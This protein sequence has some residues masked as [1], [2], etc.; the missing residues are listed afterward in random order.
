MDKFN[1]KE[2][3]PKNP[4]ESALI[5]YAFLKCGLPLGSDEFENEFFSLF[6]V[7]DLIESMKYYIEK[8]S[9]TAKITAQNYITN[10]GEFFDMLRTYGIVNDI[11]TDISL[12]NQLYTKAKEATLLL[13]DSESKDI[14][15]DELYEKLK[16]G[17]DEYFRRLVINDIYE[18]LDR[19]KSGKL[20]YVSLYNRF[21]SG[22]AIKIITQYALSNLTTI[23]LNIEDVD[24]DN[25]TLT[26]NGFILEL[27]D[28]L[29][30]LLKDYLRI[31][32]Y[33]LRTSSMTEGKLFVKHNG[34]PYIKYRNDRRNSPNYVA[35][36]YILKDIVNTRSAEIFASRRI[37]ELLNKGLDI[38]TVA[39]LSGI[40]KEKCEE[41]QEKN[42]NK[43]EANKKLSA[44]LSGDKEI[45]KKIIVN[46]K[47]FLKCPF[48]GKDTKAI[49]DDWVLVQLKE[50]GIK[51][52][53]CG[54]CKGAN[55]KA[56]L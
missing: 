31:R 42:Q 19:I 26:V 43:E 3:I 35:F 27:T 8:D 40:S 10:I 15:D 47:G 12:K 53:A 33:V 9:I 41:L 22:I 4:K 11:F 5:E 37:L 44:I 45:D 6:T 24:I 13:K 46:K 51:Y 23:S 2:Y 48:C 21:I 14:A 55:R 29:K 56:V 32:A 18:E 54:V 17:L 52:L 49:S 7:D 36:F 25:S 28:E 30:N 39:Q 16:S 20:K 38:S 34:E 50:N 1:I